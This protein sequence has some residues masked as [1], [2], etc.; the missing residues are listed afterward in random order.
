MTTLDDTVHRYADKLTRLNSKLD[1]GDKLNDT[2]V[3]R[4]WRVRLKRYISVLSWLSAMHLARTR[5]ATA[6]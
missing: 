5:A 6:A 4:Q 2:Q 3:P 1:L